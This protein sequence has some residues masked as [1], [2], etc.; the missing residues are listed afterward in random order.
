M[1]S[2]HGQDRALAV[3]GF[4]SPSWTAT[5]YRSSRKVIK[6]GLYSRRCNE[7]TER[8]PRLVA[9]LA[10]ITC[11]SAVIDAELCLPGACGAPNFYGL[12]AAMRR[13][14]Q[15]E[16]VVFAFDMVHRDACDLR[17]LPLI[18]RRR[19]P[20]PYATRPKIVNCGGGA[21]RQC[22]PC[23]PLPSTSTPELRLGNV[24]GRET[25]EKAVPQKTA[26]AKPLLHRAAPRRHLGRHH[27]HT[28]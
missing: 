4:M 21:E 1:Q 18:E 11:R 27:E 6:S 5:A 13:D 20:R 7:W 28:C 15:H 16:L 17:A 3:P 19:S 2:D 9:A 22:G 14:R 24:P 23:G 12:P 25:I 10:V 8:L 26:K